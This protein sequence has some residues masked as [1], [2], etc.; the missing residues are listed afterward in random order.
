MMFKILRDFTGSQD[1]VTTEQFKAGT[2]VEISEHLAPHIR[3]WAVPV[4]EIE[5]KAVITD[6]AQ[7]RKTKAAP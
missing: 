7:R 6:G 2:E 1:G 5:N 3:E 4:V